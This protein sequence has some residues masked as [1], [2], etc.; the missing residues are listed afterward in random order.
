MRATG[1]F[2]SSQL[3]SPLRCPSGTSA[4]APDAVTFTLGEPEPHRW[5]IVAVRRAGVTTTMAQGCGYRS[6]SGPCVRFFGSEAGPG[7]SCL[8]NSSAWPARDWSAS[9][10]RPQPPHYSRHFLTSRAARHPGR[11]HRGHPAVVKTAPKC[12]RCS[13][14]TVRHPPHPSGNASVAHGC[15][16]LGVTSDG[17]SVESRSARPGGRAIWTV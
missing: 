6:I 16:S 5:A 4:S 8:V 11:G 15:V 13:G 1:H 3:S 9:P 2:I 10:S 14:K 12:P 7:R 17:R